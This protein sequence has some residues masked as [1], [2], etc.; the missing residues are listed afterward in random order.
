MESKSTIHEKL[1]SLKDLSQMLG[2]LEKSVY[3]EIVLLGLQKVK[4]LGRRNMYSAEH[5]E[6]LQ[7][8]REFKPKQSKGFIIY[9]SK[10]NFL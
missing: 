7:A 9:Q 3:N 5:L 1:Y 8:K 10:I 2:I 6:R 4:T